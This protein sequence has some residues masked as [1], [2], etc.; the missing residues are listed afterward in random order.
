M[1]P[2]LK[3]IQKG[4]ANNHELMLAGLY[5][6]F[7]KRLLHFSQITW[8]GVKKRNPSF[9]IR[10][11]NLLLQKLQQITPLCCLI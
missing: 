1:T 7:H 11:K 4:I 9:F 5:K 8:Q 2:N 10:T 3:Y 6:L